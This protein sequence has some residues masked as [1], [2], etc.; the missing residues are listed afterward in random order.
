MT[1]AACPNCSCPDFIAA[2]ATVR[3]TISAK[4]A[5]VRKSGA[6]VRCV[7]CESLLAATPAGM[8]LVSRKEAAP[9]ARRD[10]RDPRNRDDEARPIG[11]PGIPNDMPFNR[12]TNP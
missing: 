10:P 11:V 6:M 8:T 4:E 5:K 2:T 12:R 3:I 7:R 1:D 9:D